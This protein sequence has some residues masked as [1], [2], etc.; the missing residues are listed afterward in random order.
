MDLNGNN[1]IT[2]DGDYDCT[3]DPGRWYLFTAR[4][5]FGGGTITLKTKNPT[6]GLFY[7]VLNGSFTAAAEFDFKSDGGTVRVV[8]AGA[9]SPNIPIA[10]VPIYPNA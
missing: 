7:D 2:A 5:D 4:D 10:I 8:L 6:D 3:V 9:T 1:P